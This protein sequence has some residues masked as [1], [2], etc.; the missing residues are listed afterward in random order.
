[1]IKRVLVNLT[2]D[3]RRDPAP[4]FAITVAT[5]F[6]ASL[7]GVAFAHEPVISP[8]IIAG[9]PA[10]LIHSMR[11]QS[12]KAAKDT[13]ERFAAAAKAAGVSAQTRMVTATYAGAADLFGRMGRTFD[14]VLIGQAEPDE[15]VPEDMIVENALFESG[16][17][18]VVVPYIQRDPIKLDRIMVCW[19]GSRA[20]ARAVGDA[21]PL[22][23]RSKQ[24]DVVI[25]KGK[26]GPDESPATA[27]DCAQHLA[28]HGLNAKVVRLIGADIDVADMLLSYAAD[29]G[30]DFM[31]MGGYGHSK[32]REIILGGVT[33]AILAS[34]TIP[35]LMSH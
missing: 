30:A 3:G 28:G 1:M 32:L 16:R 2:V 7:T 14:V 11:A 25:V 22:L 31:V 5:T 15:D 4:D 19:D 29:S 9:M 33:R 34:M 20:A 6:G 13:I 35:V 12:E 18:I 17:P 27:A 21:L 10:D 8:S 24:I 26:D 23:A